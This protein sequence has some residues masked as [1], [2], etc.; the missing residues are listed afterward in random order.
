MSD[1]I[2]NLLVAQKFLQLGSRVLGYGRT[3]RRIGDNIKDIPL[4]KYNDINYC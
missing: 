4:D 3:E 1:I 2:N